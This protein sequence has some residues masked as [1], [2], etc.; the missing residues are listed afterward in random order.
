MR[1]LFCAFLVLFA[2]TAMGGEQD[3]TTSK[4]SDDVLVVMG[5]GGN[6]TAINT[7][8]GV[9]VVDTFISPAAARLARAEI[10]ASFPGQKIVY[11]INTHYH[12]DHTAGNQ[13]FTDAQLLA[14]VNCIDRVKA[15][16]TDRATRYAALDEEISALEA[17]IAAAGTAETAKLASMQEQLAEL[18]SVHADYGAF[19]LIPA[20]L[21]LE[22][23]ARIELGEK[24]FHLL[25]NGP[26]HTNGDIV[27]HCPEERLLIMGD[28]LFNRIIP[29]IDPPAGA[30]VPQWIATLEKLVAMQSGYDT[31][32]PGHGELTDVSGLK[33]KIE[34]L[35]DL[36][37]AVSSAFN[38][39]VSLEEAKEQIRL[40]KYSSYSRY[41][42]LPS[43]I[44]ACWLILQN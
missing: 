38:Q 4:L 22:A 9:V 23:G 32:I 17:K 44:E 1:K 16:Y 24:T 19:K 33:L 28:L 25:Y 27:I 8:E 39:G 21:G 36:W 10:E 15:S 40:D 35:N 37:G 30:D 3:I 42:A 34:Y 11:V 31:V 6:I 41:G 20:P 43:N 14:H 13:V 2:M 29:Y 26:G 12:F 5:G 18:K 7:A